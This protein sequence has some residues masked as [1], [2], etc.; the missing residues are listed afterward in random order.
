M[1]EFLADCWEFP[2]TGAGIRGDSSG[3]AAIGNLLKESQ[4]IVIIWQTG[5]AEVT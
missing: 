1:K 4:G 5:N 2:G 3:A